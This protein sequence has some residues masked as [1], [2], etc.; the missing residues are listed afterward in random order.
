MWCRFILLID[1]IKILRILFF[2]FLQI[3]IVKILLECLVYSVYFT[4][5]YLDLCFSGTPF[6]ILIM[7]KYIYLLV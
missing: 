5:V 1:T 7:Y 2:F 4:N 6:Q 3:E